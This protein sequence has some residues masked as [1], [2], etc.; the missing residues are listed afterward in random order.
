MTR[1]DKIQPENVG[2]LKKEHYNQTSSPFSYIKHV[3]LP[4]YPFGNAL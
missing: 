3:Q 2:P 4:T 1:S